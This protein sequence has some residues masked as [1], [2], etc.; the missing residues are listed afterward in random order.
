MKPC[1]DNEETTTEMPPCSYKEPKGKHPFKP[2]SR[3]HATRSIRDPAGMVRPGPRPIWD[4]QPMRV[5]EP[6]GGRDVF[7]VDQGRQGRHVPSLSVWMF[8]LRFSC[9][10][11]RWFPLGA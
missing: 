1:T 4:V 10:W 3:G 7:A 11:G 8:V 9:A 5:H 6:D 2:T